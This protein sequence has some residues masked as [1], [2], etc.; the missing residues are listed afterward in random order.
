MTKRFLHCLRI[1]F[2]PD[3]FEKER[4]EEVADFCVKYGFENVMLFINAE[5]YNVGHMTIEE[6]RPWVATMKR[7]KEALQKRG[8]SV[9]LNPWIELGHLDRC[10]PLKEGQNF[11]TQV[12]YDG[13]ACKMVACP[14]CENW[15][16]YFLQ[17]YAYLIKELEPDTVWVED[18]FRLHNHGDLKFGGCFCDLHIKKYNERL[19]T[20]YTREEFTDRLF[21]KKAEKRVKKVWLDVNR[22]CMRALAE[23][24]GSAVASL[25]LG[26]KVGLMSSAHDNHA[27]EGRDWHGVHRGIAAGGVAI[28]RLHL[29]CYHEISGKNYYVQFNRLPFQCR[30]LLPKNT[31]VYPELENGSFNTFTKEARF[32]RFQL[33][34]ALPLCIEG[35]TYDIYDFVGNGIAANFGYG[36]VVKQITPYLNGVINLNLRYES[37]E[38]LVLPIDEKAVYKRNAQ[39]L[40]FSDLKPDESVFNAFLPSLGVT[41]RASTK[42]RFFAKVVALGGGNAYN[43]TKAQLLAL[44]RDNFVVL[45]G[46]AARILIDRG[47][48]YLFG[49]TG[50][51]TYI[52]EH[53][54]QSFEEV[55]EGIEIN[56]KSG[57][58]ATAFG[59]AGDYVK[60]DYLDEKGAQS[61]VYDYLG[62]KIGAGA[63][64]GGKYF[65]IPY[66]VNKVLYEQYHDLRTTLLKD[67]LHRTGAPLVY[68]H[69]AGVYAYLYVQ[70]TR[71]I[72][73][74]V[75]STEED[76]VQ[77]DLR[78]QNVAFSKL[79]TVDRQSGKLR[80]VPFTLEGSR[81]R[82]EQENTHLTTSTYVL[83]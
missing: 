40:E 44:F 19:G 13:N 63:M 68:T 41:C 27:L 22:E 36:E 8:I 73:I 25:R 11:T 38:G 15:K 7:A 49:A 9:S 52:A 79:Q 14:L 37:L 34:S 61:F 5:E 76:F 3:R 70:K 35:M 55:K 69:H 17:F 58:R 74:V 26:T 54:A 60:I 62:N 81:L 1:Q 45:E 56:R 29:P 23:D 64:N 77:T 33:E 30:A 83:Q 48:G 18:D 65:V 39:V 47:L 16:R 51:K 50:Y 42:K 20:H 59:K 10:R 71:K 72:L 67:F 32:L 21:R 24:L 46:G 80:S 78:L 43:F 53:G 82:I 6:A 28:D 75:N 4:I 2:Y 12:D 57:Y 31:V 66:V